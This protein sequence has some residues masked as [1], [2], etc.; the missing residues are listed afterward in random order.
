MTETPPADHSSSVTD[1]GAESLLSASDL[2]AALGEVDRLLGPLAQRNAPLGSSTTY[3]VGG[4]AALL[5]QINSLEDLYQVAEAVAATGIRALVVGRGSNLLVGDDGFHG[6]VVGLGPH[7]SDVTFDIDQAK[8]VVHV[9]AAT[10]MPVLARRCVREGLSGMEWAVGIPG[11]VGGAVRMNAGGHGRC[12]SDCLITTQLLDLSATSSQ[13]MTRGVSAL[14]YGYRRSN[15]GSNKIVLTADFALELDT[16][17]R[18][19][20]TLD[21]IVRWRRANQ[22]GG[23]NAGS[24][25]AN[26]PGDSAGRLIEAA[27][28]KGHRHGHAVVSP[29]HANFI[30]AEPGASAADVAALIMMVRAVVAER[31]GVLLEL[32]VQLVGFDGSNSLTLK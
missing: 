28:M 21:D 18:G 17:G 29:K 32:E 9:G 25:F 23:A 31:L 16:E 6:L 19:Q 2:G 26:P 4:N 27:G 5:A 12:V 13:V 11:S 7:F 8:P 24:V 3:R 14:D 10:P 1:S 30:Q 20:S 22:P 15:I